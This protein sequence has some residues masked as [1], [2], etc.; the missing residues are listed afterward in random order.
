MNVKVFLCPFLHQYQGASGTFPVTRLLCMQECVFKCVCM[1]VCA[2]MC[3]CVCAC[4]CVC[5][6]VRVRGS[7]SLCVCVYVAATYLLSMAASSSAT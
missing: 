3:V 1:C 6:R 7:A 2:C 4:V 5:V